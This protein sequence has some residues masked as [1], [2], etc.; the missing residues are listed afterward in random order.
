MLCYMQMISQALLGSVA[1]IKVRDVALAFQ[2]ANEEHRNAQEA[3]FQY[4]LCKMKGM[5]MDGDMDF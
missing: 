1:Y 3:I 2:A 5:K 4:A